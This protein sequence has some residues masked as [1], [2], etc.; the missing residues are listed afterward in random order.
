[1]SAVM[2]RP[3]RTAKPEKAP[4]RREL[5]RG[6]YFG[7]VLN[8][9]SEQVWVTQPDGS[10][11]RYDGKEVWHP[12]FK[13]RFNVIS[14][15]AMSD[16]EFHLYILAVQAAAAN[17]MGVTFT[18]RPVPISQPAPLAHNPRSYP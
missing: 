18:E 3:A 5:L 8:D 16:D 4:T 6:L 13:A 9:I 12:H 15:T 2:S 11:S 7:P 1:M 14:T 10:K 17:D